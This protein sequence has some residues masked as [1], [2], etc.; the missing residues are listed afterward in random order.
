[1]FPEKET[2][3]A[4]RIRDRDR[5]RARVFHASKNV[6]GF[7]KP[8]DHLDALDPGAAGGGS[9]WT[10]T[11]RDGRTRRGIVSWDDLFEYRHLRSVL[12]AN[13][14]APCSCAVCGNPRRWSGERTHQEHKAGAA[15]AEQAR[16]AGLRPVGSGDATWR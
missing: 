3:R 9:R 5:M 7:D 10:W 6:G 1:M 12:F 2:T 8:L 11:G 16:S 13:T 14:R 4:R 15:A